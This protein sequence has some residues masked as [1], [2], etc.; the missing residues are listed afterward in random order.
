[1]QRPLETRLQPNPN[2]N[3]QDEYYAGDPQYLQV[4][5]YENIRERYLALRTLWESR[6]VTDE[7]AEAR[8]ADLTDLIYRKVQPQV[9]YIEEPES[10]Q[11]S[12][13]T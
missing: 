9:T 8:I 2:Y 6:L 4:E 10:E 13:S 3:P 1:M 12:S 7:C 11:P 5:N